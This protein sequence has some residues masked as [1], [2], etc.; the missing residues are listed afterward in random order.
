MNFLTASWTAGILVDPPTNNTSSI[1]DTESPASAKAVLVGSIVF[2][3][4]WW[5]NSSNLA[6]DKS[7][8]I[9][10]GPLAVA[11]MN[12]KFIFEL[13]VE[14]NSFLAFSAAS[15]NLW[16]AILSSLKST[17]SAFLNSSAK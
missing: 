10:F 2:S 13:I 16:R 11:V 15:F 12:G 17:P 9:C 1:S 5:V 6:L 7:I 8:F 4:K 3:T 14:D